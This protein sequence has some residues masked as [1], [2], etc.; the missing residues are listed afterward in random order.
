LDDS[1]SP[2]RLQAP[3]HRPGKAIRVVGSDAVRADRL[4]AGFRAHSP[5]RRRLPQADARELMMRAAKPNPAARVHLPFIRRFSAVV[6]PALFFMAGP[7]G[8]AEPTSDLRVG[9]SAVNL[10][11]DES[12]V[13]AGFLEAHYTKEQEGELRSVA[14]VVEK[15]GADKVA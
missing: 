11:C 3:G 13:L 6:G 4:Q 10:R 9:A 2:H 1:T 15:P 8:A 12:M 14:V 7:L 5:H